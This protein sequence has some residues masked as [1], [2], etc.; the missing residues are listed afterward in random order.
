[1]LATP[2]GAAHRRDVTLVSSLPLP[3]AARD[4]APQDAEAWPLALLD[5]A[6]IPA[7]GVR[8]RDSA[9]LGSRRLQLGYPWVETAASAVLPE[10]VEAP[11]GLLAGT[12]AA[13]SLRLGAFR[14]VAGSLL[15]AVRRTLPELG[16]GAMRRGLPDR[17]AADWLGARLSLVTRR[18]DG[19][20]LL[21]DATMAADAA[22]RPAGVARLMGILL[23]AARTLGQQRIFDSSGPALWAELRLE[24]EA[25]LEKLRAAGALDGATPAEAYTVRCDRSTMTQSDLDNGRVVATLAFQPAYPVER[26]TATLA[27]AE[28][29]LALRGR[30]A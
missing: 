13:T 26:I 9:G 18:I 25:L 24:L 21:S 6:G 5:E 2:R 17:D 27:L 30:A 23:R 20:A 14:S 10:G 19:F 8:L 22:W 15:P 7:P 28:A 11:E 3:Q 12:I 4:A 16:T 29:G 1:M